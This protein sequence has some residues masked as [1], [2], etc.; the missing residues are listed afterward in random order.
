MRPSITTSENAADFAVSVSMSCATTGSSRASIVSTSAT[1]ITAGNTSFDDC[2]RLTSSFGWTGF[3]DPT[4]PPAIWIARFAITS[5]AFMFDCVPEPVW[6][7][8]SGNSPSSAPS[9]TSR[10]ARSIS[11]A[12]AASSTPSF[13][14]R[15]R[16]GELAEPEGADH[17]PAPAVAR[18]AD[19]EVVDR[20]LRLRA[21]QPVGGHAHFAHRVLLDAFVAHRAM[22]RR[23]GSRE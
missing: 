10:A 11:A 12:F 9:T 15:A 13:E 4:T 21:P 14:V 20:A 3:F 2:E 17:R 1:C 23:V 8:T 7:A 18:H 16:R 22:I 6:K 19:R 5:F